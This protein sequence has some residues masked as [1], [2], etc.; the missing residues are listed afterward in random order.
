MKYSSKEYTIQVLLYIVMFVF[1]CKKA[2]WYDVKTDKS[3]AIPTTL[4]DMQALMDN[5]DLNSFGVGMGEIA[6]DGGY[7]LDQ[8]AQTLAPSI[9]N[10][11]TWSHDKLYVNVSDWSGGKLIGGYP[12]IFYCN[13]VLEGLEKI[14]TTNTEDQL[15]W[16]NIK[17][18]AHFMRAKS[19]YELSQVFAPPFEVAT[20]AGKLG[21]PLRLESDVNIPS[22]R[23][24]LKQT[25]EQIIND[26]L[27]ARGVLPI[28][29]LYKTRGS[30]TAVYAMLARVYLSMEDYN[31]AGLYADSCLLIYNKL[32]NYNSLNPSATSPIE[33]FNPEVIFHSLTLAS[34][35]SRLLIDPDLYSL[36]ENNDLRRIVFYK[37]NNNTAAITFKGGYGGSSAPFSGIATDEIYLIRA[38]CNARRNKVSAAMNDLNLLLEN[39]FV[40]GTFTKLTAIDANDA[41]RQILIERRKELLVRGLR[42]SDLRRLNRDE[43]F[44]VTLTRTVLGKTYILPP[45]SYQYTFPIPD[46]IISITGM[47][48][49]EGWEK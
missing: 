34:L 20:A 45:N 5:G 26:L 36:Y 41:L 42:W 19:F 35:S 30:K 11:Y 6:S 38:E 47:E 4:G 49:N 28:T 2:E 24:T 13:L 43:R 12:K 14:K 1:G 25:Y 32:L 40:T 7:V 22:K 10:A 3:L 8:S 9:I 46:D 33:I 31:K 18:Q 39:R 44:K 16:N 27:I 48:Q 29:P 37:K 21:L 23:S 15:K 17:G